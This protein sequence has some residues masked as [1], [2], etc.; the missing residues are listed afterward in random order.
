[1]NTAP[2]VLLGVTGS[3]A[4]YKAIEVARMLRNRGIEVTAAL[5]ET[6]L[7]LVQP[8][9]F[10]SIGCKQ[11]ITR[12]TVE[13]ERR[14][15]DHVDTAD[16]CDVLAVA[17]ATADIMAKIACGIADDALS[18][19]VLAFPVSKPRIIAP[20]MNTRMWE[21]PATR[22]NVSTLREDGWEIVGPVEGRLADGREG[23]GKM[24]DVETIV[25]SITKHLQQ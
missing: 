13:P 7:M 2:E 15:S 3:V 22:R 11:V 23:T 4:A 1:M 24:A 8:L 5:T 25:G 21:N 16:R 20:A 12:L 17:P 19:I 14:R 6:A 18:T 10:E 9:A